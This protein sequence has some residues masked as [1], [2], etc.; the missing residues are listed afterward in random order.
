MLSVQ[1]TEVA[2][3]A[4]LDTCELPVICTLTV[5]E[6][7]RAL[8]GGTAAEAVE[9]LQ[10]QGASA[11]GVNCSVGP[12]QLK[13]V[14]RAMKE[15]ARIPIVVKPNAGMPEMDE[16]GQPVLP[17]DAGAICGEHERTD[18]PGRQPG[19]RMLRNGPGIHPEPCG[20]GRPDLINAIM[21]GSRKNYV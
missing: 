7:G 21:R 9:T 6:N 15:K 17:D 12:E 11:V 4:A 3:K 1:E 5:Q 10:A 13:D 8:F 20:S 16:H 2:L 18:R 14:V 19:G